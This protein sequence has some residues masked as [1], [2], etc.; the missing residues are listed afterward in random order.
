MTNVRV[1]QHLGQPKMVGPTEKEVRRPLERLHGT[2]N[3]LWGR[4]NLIEGQLWKR[5]RANSELQKEKK[6]PFNKKI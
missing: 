2:S 4:I 3:E 5:G 1:R 6:K